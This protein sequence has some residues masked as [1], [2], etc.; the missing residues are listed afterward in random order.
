MHRTDHDDARSAG[1]C[2]GTGIDCRTIHGTTDSSQLYSKGANKT[3]SSRSAKTTALPQPAPFQNP[4]NQHANISNTSTVTPTP[5]LPPTPAYDPFSFVSSTNGIHSTAPHIESTFTHSDPDSDTNQLLALQPSPQHMLPTP[6]TGDHS[7]LHTSIDQSPDSLPGPSPF[8]WNDF[9]FFD[10]LNHSL[11]ILNPTDDMQSQID[12]LMNSM[13]PS[14]TATASAWPSSPNPSAPTGTTT[15]CTMDVAS[16]P[17]FRIPTANEVPIKGV[18][19]APPPTRN[20]EK[21]LDETAW[22]NL[23]EQ[24]QLAENVDPSL[25]RSRVCV[26]N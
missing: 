25:L 4:S 20:I 12:Q 22:K 24:I 26:D 5:V 1:A 13:I 3:D 16:D 6:F 19:S 7:Q 18:H 8:T 15:T 21:K 14:G 17:L 10:E 11:G 23:V 9:T 2:D